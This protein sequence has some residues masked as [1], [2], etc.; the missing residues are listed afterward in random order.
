VTHPGPVAGRPPTLFVLAGMPGSGKSV[1]AA[2][3]AGEREALH[4]DPDTW[5]MALGLDPHDGQ[6][7]EVFE[8]LQWQQG[9]RLLELGVSVIAES[10]GWREVSRERRRVAA[11]RLGA[12]TELH[13]LDVDLE[14]R[15]RRV[16]RRNR[17]PGA[18]PL[19]RAQ[20]DQAQ[21]FWEPPGPE[22]Q[23]RYDA[24]HVW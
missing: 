4:L 9:L 18:V 17:E 13:V 16:E 15:W 12:R 7:R 5:F 2:R 11:A 19:T 21:R 24:V 6:A 10:S 20:L 1:L 22:E 8:S 14:E 3:L 23:A